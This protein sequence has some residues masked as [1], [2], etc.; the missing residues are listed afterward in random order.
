MHPSSRTFNSAPCR[1]E[2][3]IDESTLFFL[4]PPKTSTR[5][6]SFLL[7][8]SKHLRPTVSWDSVLLRPT[9]IHFVLQGPNDRDNLELLRVLLFHTTSQAQVLQSLQPS[10]RFPAHSLTTRITFHLFQPTAWP[11]FPSQDAHQTQTTRQAF[12]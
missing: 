12:E 9:R 6:A 3:S 10:I 4:I 7:V 2:H 1:R 8:I 11:R 5:F